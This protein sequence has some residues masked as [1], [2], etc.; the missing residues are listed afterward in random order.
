MIG[1]YRVEQGQAAHGEASGI[2]SAPMCSSAEAAFR[3][4]SRELH[5]GLGRF[6]GIF[7]KVDTMSRMPESRK[8]HS[9]HRP[10]PET[11]TWA[12]GGGTRNTEV[13][14]R[15]IGSTGVRLP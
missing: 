13:S 4:E 12:G 2:F 5:P 15:R 8:R 3:L 1:A 10:R 7:R 9:L 11:E 6:V 14:G